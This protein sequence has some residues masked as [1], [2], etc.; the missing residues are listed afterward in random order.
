MIG[1]L[2]ERF[3]D[4]NAR[5]KTVIYYSQTADKLPSTHRS[6][7]GKVLAVLLK[8]IQISTGQKLDLIYRIIKTG[9]RRAKLNR[10]FHRTYK[11]GK[12]IPI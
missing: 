1:Q 3:V 5:P 9:N 11:I 10:G 7:S 2:I 4:G 6:P 8:S 12:T